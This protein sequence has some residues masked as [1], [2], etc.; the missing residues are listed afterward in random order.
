MLIS[1][2][3]KEK[4]A[5]SKYEHYKIPLNCKKSASCLLKTIKMLARTSMV[6]RPEQN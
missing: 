6:Y 4:R 3:Y 5:I 1:N 2:T